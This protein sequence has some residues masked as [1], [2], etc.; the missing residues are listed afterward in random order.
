[1]W[2]RT[3]TLKDTWARAAELE[4]RKTRERKTPAASAP[5][6]AR[7]EVRAEAR[8][9]DPAAAARFERL[10]SA[11]GLAEN[12]AHLLSSDPDTAAYFEA[13]VAAGARPSTASRWLLNELAG[14]AGG[15]PLARL[16]LGGAHFGKFIALIDAGRLAPA[17]GKTLLAELLTNGG[18][19][20]ARMK[21][22]G[23][24]KVSDRSAVVAAVERALAA[25]TREVER[26][27]AGE[28]KLLG[29][30]LG[31]AMRETQGAADPALVRQVLEARLGGR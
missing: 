1:V 10:R 17:A 12:E 13:A 5:A 19:P 11:L 8:A 23:L 21:A 15:V 4:P 31:A 16:P 28:K 9:A 3:S 24:E 7:D 30:L 27:R 2:N 22:L 14:A 20:E 18:D 6:R 25:S 26:Y 29:V